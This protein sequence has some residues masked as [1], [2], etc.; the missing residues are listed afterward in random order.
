M[1][2][3]W[4]A[5]TQPLPWITEVKLH[6]AAELLAELHHPL[7]G[8]IR[9]FIMEPGELMVTAQLELGSNLDLSPDY[10][11]K[12]FVEIKSIIVRKPG[13]GTGFGFMQA[14]IAAARKLGYGVKLSGP[15]TEGSLR[16]AQKV[17]MFRNG[18]Y[19]EFII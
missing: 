17:G 13:Q 2:E 4:Q 18:F 6:D 9:Y 7:P 5:N 12:T 1:E 15:Y 3:I 16:L 19:S 11:K 8:L 10:A 14:L